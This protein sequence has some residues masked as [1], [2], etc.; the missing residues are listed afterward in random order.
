MDVSEQRHEGRGLKRK[1]EKELRS[2]RPVP[3]AYN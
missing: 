3:C 2:T 1:L